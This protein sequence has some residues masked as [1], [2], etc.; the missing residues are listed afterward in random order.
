MK[1]DESVVTLYKGSNSI[2]IQLIRIRLKEAGI[3]SD[4][5]DEG[6]SSVYHLPDLSSRIMVN[7]E[8]LAEAKA[9]VKEVEGSL[10]KQ[11][12]DFD[13]KDADEEDIAFE[14]AVKAYDDKLEK[15]SLKNLII[16]LIVAI[17]VSFFL[18]RALN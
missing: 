4:L 7:Q 11:Q 17:I 12:T 13:F 15:A 14:K 8:D 16:F 18:F 6:I 1:V 3:W 10:S 5:Y 2:V 9:I